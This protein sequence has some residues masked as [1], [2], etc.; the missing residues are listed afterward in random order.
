MRTDPGSGEAAT[1]TGF[2]TDLLDTPINLPDHRSDIAEDLVQINGAPIID[3]THFSLV[4]EPV[5]QVRALG[6]LEHRR[7][8]PAAALAHRHQLHQ[9][10]PYPRPVPSRQ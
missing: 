2:N 4:V 5:A 3:Y 1:R 7:R 10:P 6:G 8:P 9:R